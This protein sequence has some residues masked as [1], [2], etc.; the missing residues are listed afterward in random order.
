MGLVLGT[1]TFLAAGA[2][3]I[4]LIVV[5]IIAF[6][7]RNIVPLWALILAPLIAFLIP[8][9]GPLIAIAILFIAKKEPDK[10]AKVE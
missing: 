9:I 8:V 1:L 7:R 5:L 10:V 6:K 4:L 2:Q 3:L